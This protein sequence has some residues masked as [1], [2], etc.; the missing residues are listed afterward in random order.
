MRNSQSEMNS[1]SQLNH[2]A[3]QVFLALHLLPYT[4]LDENY[5][6]ICNVWYLRSSTHQFGSSLALGPVWFS[7]CKLFYSVAENISQF[8]EII[9][10][11]S[12]IIHITLLNQV[13]ILQPVS[14]RQHNMSQINTSKPVTVIVH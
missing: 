13:L 5:E 2:V 1:C 11:L 6:S 12:L 4:L 9:F 8:S 3:R 7:V 10:V 14:Y